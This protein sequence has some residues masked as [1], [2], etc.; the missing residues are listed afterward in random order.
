VVF[1]LGHAL[2]CGV[3]AWLLAGS[4][5]KI[6][7]GWF[8][9]NQAVAGSSARHLILIIFGLMLFFRLNLEMFYLLR[10]K[11][12]WEEFGGVLFAVFIYQ[13]GFALL[14]RVASNSLDAFDVVSMVLFLVGS[15][16]NTGS[17]FQRKRFKDDP[18]NRGK[19]Y[20]R[21]LFRYARHINY[22]GDILWV[23]GWALLTRNPWSAVIPAALTG[24]FIFGFIPPLAAHLKENY[25]EQYDEW[26]AHTKKL[27]PFIY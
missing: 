13:I 25:G 2:F 21:G 1:T 12:G 26:A 16:L 23:S 18:A 5:A 14:G 7:F 6:V 9:S 11:F 15:Y 8:G 4:G 20:T 22:F 10:R 17:E 27:I 3:A 24:G 19:L